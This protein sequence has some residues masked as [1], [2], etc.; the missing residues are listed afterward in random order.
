M[1]KPDFSTYTDAEFIRATRRK[2][3]FMGLSDQ[4]LRESR[5]EYLEFDG[6]PKLKSLLLDTASVI[7]IELARRKEHRKRWPDV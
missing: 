5:D 1:T 3:P 7:E 4:E 6:D 2:P